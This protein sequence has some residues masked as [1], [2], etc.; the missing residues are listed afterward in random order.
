MFKGNIRQHVTSTLLSLKAY[1]LQEIQKTTDLLSSLFGLLVFVTHALRVSALR[2]SLF[3]RNTIKRM[4][5]SKP[6][7]SAS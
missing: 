3:K 1:D 7:Q 2:I 4:S 6:L 5:T